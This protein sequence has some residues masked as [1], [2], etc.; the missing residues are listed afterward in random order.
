MLIAITLTVLTV[1]LTY[2]ILSSKQLN[3][4]LGETSKATII[5]QLS[6]T[7]P[8][9]TFYLTANVMFHEEGWRMDYCALAGVPDSIDFCRSLPVRGYKIIILRVHTALN[10]DTGTL[11]MFTSEKWDDTKAT[12]TYLDDTINN[13]LAKVRVTAN[14]TEY[15]GITPNFVKA[16]NGN[17]QDA[18]VIMMG[19]DGLTNTRMAEAFIEK[20]AKI[21]IGWTGLVSA[22][23]TDAA[24]Q[25]LLSHLLNE[26]KTVEKAVEDTLSEVGRDPTYG[27]TLSYYPTAA[28]QYRT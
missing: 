12:T 27:S 25:Q 8:N 20:G 21:Y 23:H 4:N 15:F 10:P 2:A 14:S 18:T 26:K 16:M 13:R 5:D 22:E 9:N 1:A 7:Y 3:L 17:F 19:C 6:S 11:A 28:G 24:T